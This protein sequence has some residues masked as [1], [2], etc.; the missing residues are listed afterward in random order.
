MEWKIPITQM[1]HFNNLNNNTN[2]NNNK[3]FIN[4]INIQHYSKLD[5]LIISMNLGFKI[6]KRLTGELIWENKEGPNYE[7]FVFT[8]MVDQNVEN[9]KNVENTVD[10]SNNNGFIIS[11]DLNLQKL[12]CWNIESKKLQFKLN[13]KKN[14]KNF[15][16]LIYEPMSPV[17][18]F[19]NQLLLIYEKHQNVIHQNVIHHN[20][21]NVEEDNEEEV[22]IVS[23]L[24]YWKDGRSLFSLENDRIRNCLI[25][26]FKEINQLFKEN[27][28]EFNEVD[29]YNYCKELNSKDFKE[30][31]FKENFN[32]KVEEIESIIEMKIVFHSL[33]KISLLHIVNYYCKK[34]NENE[35]SLQWKLLKRD[36]YKLWEIKFTI[37]NRLKYFSTDDIYFIRLPLN[38]I[39]LQS[40]NKLLQ[41][42]ETY[43]PTCEN[44][45]EKFIDVCRINGQNGEYLWKTSVCVF[46]SDYNN[47]IN[48]YNNR[49]VNH[50][51]YKIYSEIRDKN[52][53]IISQFPGQYKITI[54]NIENGLPF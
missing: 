17:Q 2:L 33:K 6:I 11:C 30:L 15:I 7:L 32:K 31:N 41:Q 52:L 36:V 48:N 28:K 19:S 29:R 14:C 46:E 12:Y 38:G 5:Y 13:F 24:F 26:Y 43:S 23:E 44:Q 42:Q 18:I 20:V 51:R 9:F 3:P 49:N 35:N 45:I 8:N 39:T 16:Q 27:Y 53:L 21:N 25:L 1:S 47:F 54:L 4:C 50:Q 10:Q 40:R 22:I 37:E 34:V